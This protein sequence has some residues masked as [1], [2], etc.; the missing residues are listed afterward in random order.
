MS[1]AESTTSKSADKPFRI[2]VIDDNKCYAGIVRDYLIEHLKKA[3]I[4]VGVNIWEIKRKLAVHDYKFVIADISISLYGQEIKEALD[5][6]DVPVYYWTPG[7][8][9]ARTMGNQG[10]KPNNLEQIGETI[11][12]FVNAE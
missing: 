2:L 9:K 10:I 3:T 12:K 5:H 1:K 11:S 8:S 6:S 4:D 7:N